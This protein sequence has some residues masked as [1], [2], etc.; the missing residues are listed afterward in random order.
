MEANFD[1]VLCLN[2][3]EYL[4]DPAAVLRTLGSTLKPGGRLVVLTP[5]SPALIG[6]AVIAWRQ[7]ANC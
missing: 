7:P 1:T 4:D 5:N 2:V 3:L 6:S